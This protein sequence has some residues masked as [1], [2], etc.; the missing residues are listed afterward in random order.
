MVHQRNNAQLEI[1]SIADILLYHA[2][3]LLKSKRTSRQETG[4]R[5]RKPQPHQTSITNHS[6][7]PDKLNNPILFPNDNKDLN[8]IEFVLVSRWKDINSFSYVLNRIHMN[9]W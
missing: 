9:W 6:F 8:Y 2:K 1:V 3:S 7:I 4:Q 5:P